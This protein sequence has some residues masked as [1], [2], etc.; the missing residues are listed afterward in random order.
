MAVE[1][2]R[3]TVIF[4]NKSVSTSVLPSVLTYVRTCVTYDKSKT[5][6]AIN[7]EDRKQIA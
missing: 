7:F 1:L 3:K 2:K 6:R 5:K 4:E